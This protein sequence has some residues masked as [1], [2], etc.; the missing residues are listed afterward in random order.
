MHMRKAMRIPLRFALLAA[1][2]AAGCGPLSPSAPSG[3]PLATPA[4]TGAPSLP[5]TAAPSSAIAD[6]EGLVASMQAAVVAGDQAT[7]LALVD[8]SDPV[9]VL[10]HTR[11]SDEWSG[12]SPVAEYALA[13]A[14]VVAD[15]DAATGQLTLRWMLES[16]DQSRT[17]TFPVRFARNSVGWRYAGE[18]WT[19]TDVPHFRILVAP[20]LDG[21]VAGIQQDLPRIYDHVTAELGHAPAGSMQIKVYADPS[22]LVANTLL[23]LPDILGWNEPGEA[24]KVQIQSYEPL[25]PGAPVLSSVIAHEFTHFL[26]FDRAG[27]ERTRMPWW[28]D[29]GTATYVARDF[30]GPGARDRL[31]QVIAWNEAGQ[32]ADW[33]AMAV[34]EEAPRELWE[35]AY[36]QGYA[37][38]RYVSEE[39]GDEERNAWLAAMATEMDIDQATQ[40]VLELSFDDLDAGFRSWL[41]AQA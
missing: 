28:L 18:V 27:T 13:V 12:P 31:A 14:D 9:F 35:F 40:A 5:S 22:D 19:A 23:S 20:G 25:D 33:D 29:E 21:W 34:F 6:I 41:G 3:A 38:V 4:L 1:V 30:E 7:Y 24:L 17:A 11:W 8:L 36:P 2:L 10:E 26:L 15:G 32:L 16:E 39:Y 37:M